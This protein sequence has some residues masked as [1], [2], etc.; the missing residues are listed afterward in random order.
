MF[1]PKM[2]DKSVDVKL[3]VIPPTTRQLPPHDR[4]KTGIS[5]RGKATGIGGGLH[6]KKERIVVLWSQPNRMLLTVVHLKQ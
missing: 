2:F 1:H 5:N 4:E 6:Y 3:N